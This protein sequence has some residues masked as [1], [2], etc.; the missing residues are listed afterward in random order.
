MPNILKEEEIKIKVELQDY[1]LNL[2]SSKKVDTSNSD[3]VDFITNLLIE[4]NNFFEYDGEAEFVNMEPIEQF[5]FK[6]LFEK[7]YIKV[8]ILGKNEKLSKHEIN[9]I[10]N[11]LKVTNL[12]EYN[13][14]NKNT[15][16]HYI[17]C[18]LN[19]IDETIKENENS[20]KFS[21]SSE[22]YP[23]KN[24]EILKIRKAIDEDKKYMIELK[25]IAKILITNGADINF[26]NS[27]GESALTL[28]NIGSIKKI[29]KS[30]NNE[31]L[32]QQI[33]SIDKNES[34]KSEYKSRLP[35]M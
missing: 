13:S 14:N 20:L 27:C 29:L 30:Q 12:A 24:S 23:I 28:A 7:I 26:E 21:I 31:N 4:L 35:K 3:F 15:A 33:N 1:L 18:L 16:L 6:I 19:Q 22:K 17:T 2:L 5:L 10:K 9:F 11:I 32:S 34:S 25:E 8:R